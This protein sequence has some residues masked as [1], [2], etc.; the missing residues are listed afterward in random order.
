MMLSQLKTFLYELHFLGTDYVITMNSQDF[1]Y[2]T[3]S[4]DVVI[5]IKHD[6]LV[7][8]NE[9][10]YLSLTQPTIEGLNSNAAVLGEYP[11]TVVIILDD[12]GKYSSQHVQFDVS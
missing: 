7:E 8:G 9:V 10:I 1:R 2:N 4:L 6:L 11:S 5:D 12:D 3:Q